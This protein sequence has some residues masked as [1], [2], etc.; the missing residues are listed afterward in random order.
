MC[1]RIC[2]TSTIILEFA[3]KFFHKTRR[4]YM[5]ILMTLTAEMKN[6][7]A[8]NLQWWPEICFIRQVS[9]EYRYIWAP[10]WMKSTTAAVCD[11]RF[12]FCFCSHSRSLSHTHI[13]G[14]KR[15]FTHTIC[16]DK[17]WLNLHG[18]S[19]IHFVNLNT[20][21]VYNVAIPK[22]KST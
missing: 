17:T 7:D 6:E 4:A 11:S 18:L 16:T 5:S 20:S 19:A 2:L 9:G 10:R 14:N 1:A 15:I 22:I 12:R 3:Y 21:Y 13:K 8:F